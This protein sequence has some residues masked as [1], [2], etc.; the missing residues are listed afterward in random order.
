MLGERVGYFTIKQKLGEGGMGAVYLAEHEVMRKKV[1]IKVLL[2]QW[3]ED[4][5]IVPRFTNEAI[6]MGALEHPNIVNVTDCGQLA[7][8]AWYIVMEYLEGA[9]LAGFCASHAGPLSIHMTLHI[10]AQVGAGLEAAHRRGIVHRDLKLE[11]IFLVRKKTNAQFV[12]ILDW[13]ISKL[14]EQSGSSVTRTG[15]IAGTPAYMAPEQM[16]DLR[17]VDRRSDVYALGVIAYQMLTGGWLP[18]QRKDRPDEFSSLSLV[19]IHEV[20]TTQPPVD[21]RNHVPSLDARVVNAILAAIHPDPA[22]RPQSARAF[23]LMLAAAVQGDG[24]NR[25]GTDIVNEVA[26]ELLEIGNLEET[27][28]ALKASPTTKTPSRYRFGDK[29][30]AGGMAEVFRAT[31]LGAEGFSRVVAVKRVLPGFSSVPQFASM[32]VQEAKLASLLTHPNVVSVLDFD[33]DEEGRLFLAMEYVEGRDLAALAATGR[34]PFSVII[35]IV[36]ETLRGLGYA[37][38]LPTADGPLGLIHR[39]V[40]PQ[41]VLLSWEG[42]VKVSDFGIAKARDASQATASTMIKGKPQYMSPEQAKGEPLDGRSDLFAVGIMLWELATGHRLFEGSTQ[43]SLARIV[44]GNIPPPSSV[45]PDIPRDLEAVTMTLLANTREARYANAELAI[46]DLARCVD[47]P[48]NGRTELARVLAE[49]FPE[50]LAARMSRPQLSSPAVQPSPPNSQ[51]RVTVREQ[52]GGVATRRDPAPE[53]TPWPAK[54]TLGS[55]ASQSVAPTPPPRRR[56]PL[57]A[58]LIVGIGGSFAAV[59]AYFAFGNSDGTI[60]QS[61]PPAAQI[62]DAG[63]PQPEPTL[64]VSTEPA[65]AVVRVDGTERGPSPVVITVTRGQRVTLEVAR[66]G[67]EPVTRIVTISQNA[68]SILLALRPAALPPDAALPQADAALMAT[69]AAEHH[70]GTAK[71]YSRKTRPKSDHSPR[72]K[73]DDSRR[74]QVNDTKFNPDDVVE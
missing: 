9:T 71:G 43:E 28:R 69:D 74:Q 19:A 13:G 53:P 14:G 60:E 11:N 42:A 47:A 20:L 26:A 6:A 12:K 73:S 46:E 36:S 62:T 37:H 55:A 22:R 39:D 17:T 65:G 40:S 50:A 44:F 59:G 61:T 57:I 68:E 18:F 15:M 56:L 67:Y 41:N 31:Q 30:G 35:F 52:P 8:G 21:P 33:R 32:F 58:S 3:T 27:V 63:S 72:L 16:K 54:T 38:N 2:P 64:T 10:L 49:R 24:Y 51:S 4:P 45:S 7:N 66:D 48:R 5:R 29:L 1:A 70:D 34:L 25:S 23:I